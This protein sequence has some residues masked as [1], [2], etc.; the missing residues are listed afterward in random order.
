MKWSIRRA[1]DWNT[2]VAGLPRVQ[3]LRPIAIRSLATPATFGI[4]VTAAHLTKSQYKESS[5]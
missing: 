4:F 1:T 2:P 3:C 5:N